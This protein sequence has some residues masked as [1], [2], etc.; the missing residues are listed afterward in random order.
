MSPSAPRSVFHG[1]S[2][3][4]SMTI[5]IGVDVPMQL[6]RSP[7]RGTPTPCTPPAVFASPSATIDSS[8]LCNCKPK[9]A[10]FQ[11][12]LLAWS[13][14]PSSI[15][16]SFISFTMAM[17]TW[18]PFRSGAGSPTPVTTDHSETG[19]LD[20]LRRGR[21]AADPRVAPCSRN[22]RQAVAPAISPLG[23]N[24]TCPPTIALTSARR[25]VDVTCTGEASLHATASTC[26]PR[27]H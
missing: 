12:R 24:P 19:G 26:A 22:V 3:S 15:A 16:I 1:G 13:F 17:L 11:L 5:P 20:G 9:T 23:G 10:I 27:A 21:G 4:I 25:M 2:T 14:M 6:V 8:I 7:S 18:M